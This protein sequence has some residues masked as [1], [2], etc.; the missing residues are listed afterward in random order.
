ML[1]SAQR[2]GFTLIELLVVLA[3][4]GVLA[5][6]VV[7][8]I[9]PIKRVRQANDAKIKTDVG[10]I[11]GALQGQY[12]LDQVYPSA[13]GDLVT[14]G[15]LKVIPAP[16]G[17][18]SYSYSISSPCSTSSCEAAVSFAL[19]DPLVAGN[20]WCWRSATGSVIEAASCAP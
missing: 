17:G 18:G 20:V 11:S 6:G 16:P 15:A 9:N 12:T 5:A 14:K 3:V 10:Q 19:Q 13:L 2:K 1:P 8:A 7:T 4:L